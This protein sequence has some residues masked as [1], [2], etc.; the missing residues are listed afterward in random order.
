MIR[1]VTEARAIIVQRNLEAAKRPRA[2]AVLTPSG[3]MHQPS[4]LPIPQ[5]GLSPTL[6]T[7]CHSLYHVDGKL[8]FIHFWTQT[9]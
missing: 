2:P 5:A 1:A 4:D 6:A 9:P 7:F 3:D 8:L